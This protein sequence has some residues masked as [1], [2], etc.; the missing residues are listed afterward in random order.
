MLRPDRTAPNL[1]DLHPPFQIDGNFGGTA[2]IAEMLLQSQE[3]ELRGEKDAVSVLDLLP[4]LPKAWPTGSVTGLKARSG[5]EVDLTWADGALTQAK[6]R[7]LL[8]TPCAVRYG[9]KTVDLSLKSGHV[10]RLDTNLR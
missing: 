4:A 9:G 1:F 7:S 8:G 2:G 3:R 6:I 10:V 5:F